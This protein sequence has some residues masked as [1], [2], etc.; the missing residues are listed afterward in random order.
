VRI[1][2]LRQNKLIFAKKKEKKII[3]KN[4]NKDFVLAQWDAKI[5][6]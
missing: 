4:D 3:C 1:I 2:Q 5:Q 6:I